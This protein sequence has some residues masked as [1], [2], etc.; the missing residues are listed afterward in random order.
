MNDAK[1]TKPLNIKLLLTRKPEL[2]KLK[3]KYFNDTTFTLEVSR[4]MRYEEKKGK[5]EKNRIRNFKK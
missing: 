3:P 5:I 1:I 2:L 4:L